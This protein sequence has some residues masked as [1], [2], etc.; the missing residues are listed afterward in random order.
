MV[1]LKLLMS[2]SGIEA[3]KDYFAGQ[4]GSPH[5]WVGRQVARVMNQ[6]NLG[7]TRLVLDALALKKA[8]KVLELGFGGGVGLKELALRGHQASGADPAL[9]MLADRCEEFPGLDLRLEGVPK[10]SWKSGSFD[11]VLGVN[12]L[13]FWADPLACLREIR[14]VL[15]KGGKAGL[16]V[17]E[18]AFVE[19]MGFDRHGFRVYSE[20]EL[21]AMFKKAG[22]SRVGIKDAVLNGVKTLAV[23]GK[24]G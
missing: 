3:F 7:M 9:D 8:S 21:M 20:T 13:Y 15:K 2:L 19:K 12:T 18:K 1:G 17:R 22:F 5:G 16:G 6:S 11:A 23:T 14:R 24:K 4:F 10:L